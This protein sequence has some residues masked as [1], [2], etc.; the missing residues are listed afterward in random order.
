MINPIIS[1]FFNDAAKVSN[2][3]GI[4]F[5]SLC[6]LYET[7][8]WVYELVTRRLKKISATFWEGLLRTMDYEIIYCLSA[9][10]RLVAGRGEMQQ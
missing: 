8:C 6:S 7:G 1:C 4:A 9:V 3:F 2:F 5:V 10:L